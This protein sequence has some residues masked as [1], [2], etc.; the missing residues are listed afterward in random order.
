MDHGGFVIYSNCQTSRKS[1]DVKSYPQAALNFFWKDLQK[2]VRIEK[3]TEFVNRDTTK[4]YFHA[5]T[6]GLVWDHMS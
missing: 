2:Q 3:K 4:R 5:R 1:K 6:R